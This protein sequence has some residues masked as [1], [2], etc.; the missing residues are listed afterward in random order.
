MDGEK[1]T[2]FLILETGHLDGPLLRHI[3]KFEKFP[4][5]I[6]RSFHNDLILTDPYVCP[7]HLV[8]HDMGEAGWVVEDLKSANGVFVNRKARNGLST[9]VASGDIIL[10]GKTRIRVYT[11]A[12][13]IQE[14]EKMD[15]SSALLRKLSGR[16]LS[17][18]L[19]LLALAGI[20]GVNYLESWNADE[21]AVVI[22]ALVM[23]A[24]A[25]GW[26]IAGKIARHRARFHGH[27][28]IVALF[29]L[30]CLVTGYFADYAEYLSNENMAVMAFNFALFMGLFILTVY[31][32]LSLASPARQK[33]RIQIAVY[34]G[35]GLSLGISAFA[36]L[37]KET[38][39]QRPLYAWNLMPYLSGLA[40]AQTPDDFLKDMDALFVFEKSGL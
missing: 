7:D 39:Y 3:H 4:V 32:H 29:A 30:S 21:I 27:I 23:V 14:A 15:Q 34:A 2:K 5:R 20:T 31:A 36:W 12:H 19:F 18:L 37:D 38:F 33:R 22:A 28:S 13:Q 1:Q 11:E 16:A 8:I 10:I 9:P 25:I 40:P 35:I 17:G 6:G 26:S 24:W